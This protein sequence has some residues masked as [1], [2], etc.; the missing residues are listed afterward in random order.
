M[1][2]TFRE[3]RLDIKRRELRRGDELVALEPQVLDLL[4]YLVRH[5]DQVVSKQDILDGVWAGRIVS[6]SALT[7]RINAVRRAIG[8][9]GAR[10]LAIRTLP[11]KGFRFVGEVNEISDD[12]P[13]PPLQPSK[14]GDTPSIA[15]LPFAD[16]SADASQTHL[17]D[18]AVEQIIAALCRLRWLS[19]IA[20]SSWLMYR[21]QAVDPKRVGRELGVRYLLEGSVRKG[22]DRVRITAQLIDT[23]TRTHLWADWC[24]GTSADFGIQDRAAAMVAAGIEPVIETAETRRAAGRPDS[25]LE[26]HDLYL[27]ALPGCYAYSARPLLQ[28]CELL[29]QAVERNPELASALAAAAGSFLLQSVG[30][31]TRSKTASKP[32]AWRNRR[33]SWKTMTQACSP[34]QRGFWDI[35]PMT[36]TRRSCWP[37]VQSHSIPTTPEAGTGMAGCASLPDNRIWRWIISK[38][39]FD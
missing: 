9:N 30:P 38:P 11:R 20:R 29:A 28:A 6:D 18:S 2:Y 31:R 16:L 15:V 25:E 36:S 22:G 12:R 13:I 39:R 35:S 34:K 24:E 19:V 1:A 7:T 21:G 3:Y 8:D 23:E 26:P 14:L 32:S 33:C 10:Q 5:R 17:A 4:I 37:N 27:R